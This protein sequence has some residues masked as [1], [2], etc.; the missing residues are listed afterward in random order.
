[1][2]VGRE[3]RLVQDSSGSWCFQRVDILTAGLPELIEFGSIFEVT[4]EPAQTTASGPIFVPGAMN[5][6]APTQAPPPT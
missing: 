6:H 3:L 2:K 5:E 1:M 4:I